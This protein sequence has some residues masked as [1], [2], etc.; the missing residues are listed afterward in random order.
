MLGLSLADRNRLCFGV[1]GD[2]GFFYDMNVLGNR[3]AGNN[4]RILL[5]NNGRGTEFRNFDHPAAQFGEDADLYIAAAGHHG[6]QSPD[7][8][9]HYAEGL[10]F[11]YMS[12]ASKDE[13]SAC[14]ARFLTPE[15]TEKPMVFEVFT[16][17]KCESD[18]LEMMTKLET[19]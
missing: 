5:I 8:V 11:E 12:A 3:H 4:L 18:A 10:G 16:D 9:K 13:Y 7:L 19:R 17:S 1:V 6:N 2:L 15:L 14:A